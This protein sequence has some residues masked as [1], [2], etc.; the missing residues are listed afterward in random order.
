MKLFLTL[1]IV[2]A[3]A[4][5]VVAA[6]NADVSQTTA[7]VVAKDKKKSKKK[8]KDEKKEGGDM[9]APAAPAAPTEGSK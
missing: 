9:A 7:E 1:A 2:A 8:K 4:T 6:D 5:P 3:F